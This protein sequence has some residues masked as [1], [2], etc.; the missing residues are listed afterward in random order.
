[1]RKQIT[2]I[3]KEKHIEFLKLLD[4]VHNNL[5]RFARAISSNREEAKDLVS[6]SILKAYENFDKL[7]DKTAFKSWIFTI[8][9]RTHKRK[10][11]RGKLFGEY[12]EDEVLTIHSNEPSPDTIL[13]IRLLYDSLAKLPSK[14]KEAIVLFEIS[15]LSLKEIRDIQG[16]TIS[17]VKTRLD[18]ARKKLKKMLDIDTEKNFYSLDKQKV[19]KKIE[20]NKEN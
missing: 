3:E 20:I 18:R 9:S 19:K 12:N 2:M 4:P 5:A 11:R 10:K 14:Q 16:G 7:I 17:G 8:A 6:E 15:G 13:D 1:M